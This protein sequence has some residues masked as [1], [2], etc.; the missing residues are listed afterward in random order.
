MLI[1]GIWSDLGQHCFCFV[2]AL[3]RYRLYCFEIKVLLLFFS[4]INEMAFVFSR[5][6]QQHV[7]CFVRKSTMLILFCSGINNMSFDLF[8]NEQYGFCFAPAPGFCFHP[9]TC[10]LFCSEIND[11]DFVLLQ[12]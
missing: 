12:H 5:Q 1:Q 8:R 4:G 2:P 3:T 10:Y 11:A 9:A 6:H 7:V